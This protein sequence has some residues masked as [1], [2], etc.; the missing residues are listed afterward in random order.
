MPGRAARPVLLLVVGVVLFMIVLPVVLL[1]LF[2]VNPLGLYLEG[3]AA[4]P[5]RGRAAGEPPRLK[6]AAGAWRPLVS[7][8]R[9][10]GQRALG[11]ARP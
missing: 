3:R 5:T 11:D 2:V 8:D 4:G 7:P 1:A 9:A 6:V 10:L